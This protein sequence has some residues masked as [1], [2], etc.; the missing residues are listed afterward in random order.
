MAYNPAQLAALQA[1]LIAGHPVTGPYNADD[2]L[3]KK[4]LIEPNRPAVD[5]QAFEV[6]NYCLWNKNRT[7]SGT[8]TKAY[9]IY[10]RIEQAAHADE[11]ANLYGQDPPIAVTPDQIGAA[12][13]IDRILQA[14]T[15]AM[16]DLTDP[17]FADWLTDLVDIGA[18]KNPARTALIGLADNQRSRVAELGLPNPRVADVTAARAL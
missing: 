15:D 14:A 11:G 2:G 18:M 4:E 6:L 1:E 7:N 16:F 13:A 12:I 5:T 17:S 10:A 9:S 3:A 8:D